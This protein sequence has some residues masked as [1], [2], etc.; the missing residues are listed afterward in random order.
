MCLNVMSGYSATFSVWQAD[1]Q[2]LISIVTGKIKFLRIIV[3]KDISINL[4]KMISNSDRSIPCLFLSLA[5]LVSL[6]N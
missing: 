4:I 5:Q 6:W 2:T 3:S 1:K